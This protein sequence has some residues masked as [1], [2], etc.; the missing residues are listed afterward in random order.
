MDKI[1]IYGAIQ[2]CIVRYK[3]GDTSIEIKKRP[4][5]PTYVTMAEI[6]EKV[7]DIVYR[8]QRVKVDDIAKP[9]SISVQRI[10]HCILYTILGMYKLFARWVS[11]L[12]KRSKSVKVPE[13][14]FEAL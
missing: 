6:V 14:Q 8:G 7:R 5:P 2:Y 12:L 1:A 4:G 3:R 13:I 11:R 9:V 10:H